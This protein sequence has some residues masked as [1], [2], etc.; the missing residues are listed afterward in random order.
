MY[1]HRALCA[2]EHQDLEEMVEVL[3]SLQPE[4]RRLH[5]G[6][7]EGPHLRHMVRIYRNHQMLWLDMVQ[8]L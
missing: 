3:L 2:D 4:L 8:E 7:R 5:L 6:Q 1:E